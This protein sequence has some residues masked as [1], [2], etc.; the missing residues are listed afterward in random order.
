MTTF[1]PQSEPNFCGAT[2]SVTDHSYSTRFLLSD[3][4]KFDTFACLKIM[5][6]I[7]LLLLFFI[8]LTI[9][10]Y[11]QRSSEL[12]VSGGL[13]YYVG[14]LNPGRPFTL[15]Q[16]AYGIFY[17]LNLNS[18]IAWQLH[19]NRGKVKGDDA[20][21]GFFPDRYL[22][23]ESPVTEIGVQFEVNFLDYFV[24]SVRH[25]ITP[26][27]FGGA[28][29][30]MFKPTGV[31][32][33]EKYELRPLT[34]EGQGLAGRPKEYKLTSVV[35]LWDLEQSSV[36]A[37]MLGLGLNGVSEKPPLIILTISVRRI[38][39]IRLEKLLGK[40]VLPD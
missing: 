7:C 5:H 30:F 14:E 17:R 12:G 20:V 6:R 8:F 26:Y 9:G 33:G 37:N 38:I 29:I 34:T 11:A 25:R 15:V 35:F 32:N 1:L 10:A 21:T 40:S 13:S 3:S 31:I 22:N 23:F 16:P 28:G 2:T 39:W 19:A 18:R 27:V 24:G 36:L 4:Q